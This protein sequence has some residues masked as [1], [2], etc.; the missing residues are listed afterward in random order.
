[1]IDALWRVTAAY[2]P[3]LVGVGA[4]LLVWAVAGEFL[5]GI[6]KGPSHFSTL[7]TGIG[8]RLLMF[9]GLCSVILIVGVLFSTVAGAPNIS[10]FFGQA[11]VS[12]VAPV[13]T[14]V[15]NQG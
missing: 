3:Y 14:P 8:G 11:G 9:A 5:H 6:V 10:G 12:T 2:W 7:V 4:L 13:P 15:P 1:M